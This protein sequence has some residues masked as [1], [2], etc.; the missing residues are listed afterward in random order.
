MH[1]YRIGEHGNWQV[2]F[3]QEPVGPGFGVQCEAAAFA[4]FLN[5]G[6]YC[7]DE[8]AHIFAVPVDDEDDASI[9]PDRPKAFD[10]DYPLE[11]RK[12]G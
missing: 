12:R 1:T 11:E 5:G 4:S 6:R 2:Y 7:P 3:E 8:I 10:G 9:H